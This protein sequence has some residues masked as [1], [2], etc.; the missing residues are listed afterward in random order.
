VLSIARH[1]AGAVILGFEH[2]RSTGRTIVG[3]HTDDPRIIEPDCV[4]PTP[5]NNLEAGI[6]YA[7]DLPLLIFKEN[8]I[9]GGV[10]DPGATEVFVYPMPTIDAEGISSTERIIQRWQSPVRNTYYRG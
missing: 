7:L 8:G 2:S 5:W 1:C 3:P 4:H 10:F 6:A 9:S